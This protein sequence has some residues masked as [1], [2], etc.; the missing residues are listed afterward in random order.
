MRRV[1]FMKK[2]EVPSLAKKLKKLRVELH[3]AQKETS[4]KDHITEPVYRTY[5]LCDRNPKSYILDRIAKTLGVRLEYLSA[6]TF[7]N[8]RESVYA[9]LENEDAFGYTVRGIDGTAAITTGYCP[10]MNFFAEFIH[11]WDGMRKKFGDHEI[12][13]KEYE[14]RKRTWDN[15]T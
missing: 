14:D 7:R 3:L 15:G 1:S 12:T 2:K 11:D 5:E 8:R 9:I 6:S 4:G 13:K 10:T